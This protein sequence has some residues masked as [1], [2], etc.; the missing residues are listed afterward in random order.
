MVL[1]SKALLSA[2]AETVTALA[3]CLPIDFGA[4]EIALTKYLKRGWPD[5]WPPLNNLNS[6][7]LK[8][9][10][11]HTD[12]QANYVFGNSLSSSS[13]INEIWKTLRINLYMKWYEIFCQA[14]KPWTL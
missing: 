5:Y 9:H 14:V 6:H 2:K 13:N 3:G 11:Y 7:K 10:T 12:S 8:E 1:I 4:K